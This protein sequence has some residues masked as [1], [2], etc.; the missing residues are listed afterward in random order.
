[1]GFS[2]FSGSVRV[3]VLCDSENSEPKLASQIQVTAIN[4]RC[5]IGE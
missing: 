1:M 4:P 3:A 5:G 2:P